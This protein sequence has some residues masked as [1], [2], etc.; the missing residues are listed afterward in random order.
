LKKPNFFIIG[1]PKCGTTA[2]CRY[3]SQHPDIFIPSI[4]EPHFFYESSFTNKLTKSLKDYMALFESANDSHL[5]VGEGTTEY[6]YSKAAIK[7]IY[8]FD[9][10]AK[11]IVMLRNPLQMS[12]SLHQQWLHS[13]FEDE[14][15]FKKAWELRMKRRNGLEVPKLSRVP[16]WLDYGWMASYSI[17]LKNVYEVFPKENVKVIIFDDFTKDTEAVFFDVLDFLGFRRIKGMEYKVVNPQRSFSSNFARVLAQNTPVLIRNMITRMRF[18][19]FLSWFPKLLTYLLKSESKTKSTFANLQDEML[20]QY[21]R[22]YFSSDIE[23]LSQMLGRN[24]T[25]LW[26]EK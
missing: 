21:L 18:S 24:L 25:K 14:K 11:I 4:K 26:L 5:A 20:K 1:A 12:V 8:D 7:N 10:N 22:E 23:I 2:M 13:L 9:N 16:E 19:P 15:D 17:H 6:L 3:L